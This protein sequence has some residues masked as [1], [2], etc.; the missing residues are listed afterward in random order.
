MIE[1]IVID[2]EVEVSP[3]T[4][5]EKFN[6]VIDVLNKQVKSMSPQLQQP[7]PTQ[8]VHYLE[9]MAERLR[10]GPYE[11]LSKSEPS[12]DLIQTI[13]EALTKFQE[14]VEAYKASLV[15]ETK[16]KATLEV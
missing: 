8:H 14:A 15:G 11:T 1:K 13:G 16:T 10:S 9:M 3:N 2:S 12:N 4:L 5:A 7:G 6:E